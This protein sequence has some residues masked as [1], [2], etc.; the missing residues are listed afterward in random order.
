M[1]N[2]FLFIIAILVTHTVFAAT[3]NLATP[4]DHRWQVINKGSDGEQTSRLPVFGGWMV[5]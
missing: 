5:K 1:K 3:E 2:I 4:T